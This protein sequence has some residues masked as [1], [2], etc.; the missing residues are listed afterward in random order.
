MRGGLANDRLMGL[1]ENKTGGAHEKKKN[2]S[3][4]MNE[5]GIDAQIS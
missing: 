5:R 2:H 4:K 1:K 3:I